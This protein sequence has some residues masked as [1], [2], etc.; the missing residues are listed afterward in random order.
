MYLQKVPKSKKQFEKNE[1]FVILSATE[2]KKTGSGS[3]SQ[4]YD[5]SPYLNITDPQHRLKAKSVGYR[6]MLLLT[7]HFLPLLD[8]FFLLYWW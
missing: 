6:V 3:V 5:P 7:I 8:H 2:E 1:L 4:W